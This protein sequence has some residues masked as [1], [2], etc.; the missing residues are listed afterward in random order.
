MLLGK[1]LSITFGKNGVS[2]IKKFQS[3]HPTSNH[4]SMRNNDDK[5]SPQNQYNDM[6]KKF[7]KLIFVGHTAATVNLVT[8]IE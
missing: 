5:S 3:E 2:K 7:I 1:T 8:I 4:F 6:Y